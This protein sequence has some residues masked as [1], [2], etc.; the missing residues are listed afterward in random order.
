MV[1]SFGVPVR[2]VESVLPILRADTVPALHGSDHSTLF[3]V[4]DDSLLII[5]ERNLVSLQLQRS[6][7]GSH[8][9]TRRQNSSFFCAVTCEFCNGQKRHTSESEYVR[10]VAWP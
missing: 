5:N 4:T 8:P 7:A 2:R 9:Y 3:H 10:R 6:Q 1:C